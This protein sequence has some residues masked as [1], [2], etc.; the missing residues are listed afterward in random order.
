MNKKVTIFAAALIVVGTI[1]TIS[2]SIAA[3]PFMT[4]YANQII[5]EAS[6]ETIIYDK[7]VD[8]KTLNINTKQL[9]IEVKPSNSDK[10]IVSQC[11]KINNSTLSLNNNENEFTIDQNYKETNF[12]VQGFGDAIIN[13][14]RLGANKIVVYVPNKVD[15]KV[16]TEAGSLILEDKNVLSE[17][18]SFNTNYGSIVL[19]KDQKNLK[20]LNIS[21][22]GN[23]NLKLSEILGFE[24][25]NISTDGSLYIDS[26]P[27]DVFIEN[28]EKYIPK[29]F[30]VVSSRYGSD[31]NI[32]TIAPISEELRI[33]NKSGYVYMNLPIDYYNIKT[34]LTAVE[35]ISINEDSSED[36]NI[37]KEPI[38]QFEG[39]FRDAK[40]NEKQYN[41]DIKASG[42]NLKK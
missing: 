31:I 1:G 19:P 28:I 41:I 20:N 38:K 35:E 30:N 14:L 22:S 25:V 8:I 7:T 39:T 11:G 21:S 27:D 36:E 26:M 15:V 24:G 4:D 6:E 29:K 9:N 42:I 3:V 37:S 17:N 18:I 2:S 40:E 10:L 16:K 5:K 12:T 32:N 33:D 23:I 34:K 13:E